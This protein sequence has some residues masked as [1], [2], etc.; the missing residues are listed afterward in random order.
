MSSDA[1][2]RTDASPLSRISV[3]TRSGTEALPDVLKYRAWLDKRI[4]RPR[5]AAPLP[6]HARR[7]GR[8]LAD[9]PRIEASEREGPEAREGP[10]RAVP[11]SQS[12]RVSPRHAAYPGEG[13]EG[14]L[15]HR[16]RQA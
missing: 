13:A 10:H 9:L 8:R 6:R 11:A 2:S 7:C 14:P 12:V 3:R 4:A 1:T 15:P 16:G 5:R